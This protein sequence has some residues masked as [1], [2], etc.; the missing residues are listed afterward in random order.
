[1][2]YLLLLTLIP[3]FSF[4]DFNGLSK[5]QQN[6]FLEISR[7]ESYTRFKKR[8]GDRIRYKVYKNENVNGNRYI[9]PEARDSIELF[10]SQNLE[11]YNHDS[12]YSCRVPVLNRF[13]N[14][15]TGQNKLCDHS[16]VSY[17]LNQD[18]GTIRSF[19]K[20][21]VYQIHYFFAGEGS[22]MMSRWGHAMFRYIVCAPER[23][24]VGPECLEDI[25]HHIVLN[26]RANV[27]ELT[28]D[29]IAGLTG[30]YPSQVL[31][32]TMAELLHEY[33]VVELRDLT[34]LPLNISEDEKDYLMDILNEEF[35]AYAGS[36]KFFT[37]NCATE[38]ADVLNLVLKNYDEGRVSII[39][40]LGLYEELEDKGYIDESVLNDKY[41]QSKGYFFKSKKNWYEPAIKK[42]N[43]FE[44][45]NFDLEQ[46]FGEVSI[47]KRRE[48]FDE[49]VALYPEQ[50]GT[51]SRNFFML[52]GQ[53]ERVYIQ[54]YKEYIN[55]LAAN[56][57]VLEQTQ[58]IV[59][60]LT[61]A[62]KEKK[63]WKTPADLIIG[64][65]YGI[66][67][68]S[69]LILKSGVVAQ[70]ETKSQVQATE[71]FQKVVRGVE[72]IKQNIVYFRPNRKFSSN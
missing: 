29:N 47:E 28:I 26:Y 58:D 55:F 48:K 18:R 22:A 69:E 57:I 46:W 5:K 16:Q 70:A 59:E 25:N 51:I 1:M 24:V 15:H 72:A 30:K 40:P 56:S 20:S 68:S 66:P 42:L 39:S 67:Q 44:E 31:F 62:M 34:S 21:R 19:D 7:W 6:E 50:F 49:L 9:T 33:N 45:F 10:Y 71:Y 17:F 35:W 61:N 41:A 63:K 52:E 64:K 12:E 8:G 38:L 54:K 14:K 2:K 11:K 13:F 43:A 36:Y 60:S 23:K 65:G 4:A 3:Y 27:M 32:S 53:A 37:K